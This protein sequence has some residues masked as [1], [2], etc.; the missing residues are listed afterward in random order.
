MQPIYPSTL[1]AKTANAFL[2]LAIVALSAC[3]L[4][5]EKVSLEDPR[6]EPMLSA[7]AAVDRAALG[8]TPISADADV[9]FEENGPTAG[10]DV[11]LHIYARTR[12]TIAFRKDGDGY[13]WIGEEETHRGPKTFTTSDGT[14]N[15]EIVISYELERVD[16]RAT[17]V[18]LRKVEVSYYG[19]NDNL[20]G[21]SDL[22]LE[23]IKPVLVEWRQ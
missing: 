9:R 21:R 14:S 19:E 16:P 15:E 11:M 13:R 2:V 3:G 5:P 8:F 4:G 22:T 7:I 12:R 10:Y 23:D 18:P 1:V 20:A 17:G 6:L